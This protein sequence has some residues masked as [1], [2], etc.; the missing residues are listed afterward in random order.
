MRRS[1]CRR[2]LAGRWRTAG[3]IGRDSSTSTAT[4]ISISLKPALESATCIETT[5]VALPTSRTTCSEPSAVR[6]A[7]G[8]L[9]GDYDNDGRR[10]LAVLGPSGVRLLHSDAKGFSDATAAAGLASL[11]G[12]VRTAAW[13]DAD[14]DGDLDLV[15]AIDGRRRR[16]RGS[17]ATTAMDASSTSRKR[18]AS[19]RRGRLPRSSR[20]TMTI[21]ATSTC[22]S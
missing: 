9:A 8:F 7:T 19:R 11:T 4:A 14:H 12:A 22:W 3:G 21:A 13:L 17:S 18:P 2:S 6:P 20:R 15:V 16:R 5:A 10:D 1:C